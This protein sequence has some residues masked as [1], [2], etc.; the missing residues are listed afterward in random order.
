MPSCCNYGSI[1]IFTIVQ[2]SQKFTH[3]KYGIDS[4]S[5]WVDIWDWWRSWIYVA[6]TAKMVLALLLSQIWCVGKWPIL[7]EHVIVSKLL[8]HSRKHF[9]LQDFNVNLSIYLNSFWNEEQK[10][11]WFIRCNCSP[12][13]N[14][15]WFNMAKLTSA[16]FKKIYNINVIILL[17]KKTSTL[18]IFSLDQMKTVSV[19]LLIFRALVCSYQVFF[20]WCFRY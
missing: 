18:H 11:F 6:E 19:A 12:N 14:P 7:G 17:T 15:N 4:E 5:H 10:R 1:Q 9:K 3:Q 20:L 2:G 8:W 13:H 16:A